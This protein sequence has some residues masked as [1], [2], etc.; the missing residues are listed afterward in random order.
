VSEFGGCSL[1]SETN[2]YDKNSSALLNDFLTCIKWLTPLQSAL[3][4]IKRGRNAVDFNDSNHISI[5]KLLITHGANVN[6]LVEPGLFSHI[7]TTLDLALDLMRRGY[8]QKEMIQVLLDAG[9]I[10]DLIIRGEKN[11]NAFLTWTPLKTDMDTT[12]LIV[13]HQVGSPHFQCSPNAENVFHWPLNVIACNRYELLTSK[14]SETFFVKLF[15]S[16]VSISSLARFGP[17]NALEL[18]VRW[19]YDC[20]IN[21]NHP[22][23]G[24]WASR[25]QCQQDISVSVRLYEHAVYDAVRRGWLFLGICCLEQYS[26]YNLNENGSHLALDISFRKLMTFFKGKPS[27]NILDKAGAGR[28][29]FL[30]C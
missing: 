7:H 23:C 1:P 27:M 25:Q 14:Q 13:W 18:A 10:T 22:F 20:N 30:H 8:A 11:G 2:L 19:G 21:I 5:L 29:K 24:R 9:A 17:Y 12:K 28:M 16:S 6:A 15:Q 4:V 3:H 26:A